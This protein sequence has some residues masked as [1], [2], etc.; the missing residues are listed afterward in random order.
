MGA[1]VGV[2][3]IVST[4]IPWY[5][6]SPARKWAHTQT[7]LSALHETSQVGRSAMKLI[8]QYGL[9]A[10]L[11]TTTI[12]SIV[13]WTIHCVMKERFTD[14]KIESDRVFIGTQALLPLP[15]NSP[16][17]GIVMPR[18]EFEH[19]FVGT[20]RQI[21]NGL[22]GDATYASFMRDCVLKNAP[23]YFC[24]LVL[25]TNACTDAECQ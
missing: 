18:K 16:Q 17:F 24:K 6:M 25:A 9:E 20:V 12:T 1:L 8:V 11:P 5:E 3:K 2:T 14:C 13:D 10:D 22:R 4:L 7:T 15:E 21:V 19:G 23:S